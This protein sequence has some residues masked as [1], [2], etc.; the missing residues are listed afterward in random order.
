MAASPEF[1][2]A[3]SA[4]DD[5]QPLRAGV[6]VPVGAR[7]RLEFDT[8]DVD[9][10]PGGIRGQRLPQNVAGE[11]F[12]VAALRRNPAVLKIFIVLR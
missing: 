8:V 7:A 2:D 12:G 11:R 1:L 4:F 5:Q 6:R 9:G 10:R 3:N